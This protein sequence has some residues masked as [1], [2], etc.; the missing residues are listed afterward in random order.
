MIKTK[1][2]TLR[3]IDECDEELRKKI[4]NKYRYIETETCDWVD[5]ESDIV[6]DML[7]HDYGFICYKDDMHWDLSCCQGSGASFT[8]SDFYWDR[9]LKDL[10]IRHKK[11]WCKYL[12]SCGFKIISIDYHYTHAYTKCWNTGDCVLDYRGAEH[13]YPH[14]SKEFDRIMQHIEDVRQ[15]ACRVMYKQLWDD[16]E[17]YESDEY[18][19]EYFN[20]NETFFNEDGE[21]EYV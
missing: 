17:Y 3:T 9:L 2:I 19:Y 7:N 20:D 13:D 11:W 6:S 18:L 15:E 10:D 14:L 16:M 12:D 5:N 4:F 1:T 8:C 21:I